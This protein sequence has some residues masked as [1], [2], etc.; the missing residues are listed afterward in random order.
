MRSTADNHDRPVVAV[1]SLCSPFPG[2]C[3]LQNRAGLCIKPNPARS[4]TPTLGFAA[5]R[6][7]VR[8]FISI[9]GDRATLQFQVAADQLAHL[10]ISDPVR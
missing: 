2:S 7:M 3:H 6:Q 8:R 10:R 9:G 5:E 4:H 1:R